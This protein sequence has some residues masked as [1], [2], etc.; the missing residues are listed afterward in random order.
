MSRAWAEVARA[1]GVVTSEDASVTPATRPVNHRS[2]VR[3]VTLAAFVRPLVVSKEC[4]RAL[5]VV[6]LAPGR[7]GNA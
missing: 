5:G 6:H 3:L 2:V 7:I 4:T 1:A